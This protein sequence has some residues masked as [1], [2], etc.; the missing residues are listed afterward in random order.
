VV[1]LRGG[2][3]TGSK[4]KTKRYLREK[5]VERNLANV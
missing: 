1:R 4:R 5:Q 3:R 2:G